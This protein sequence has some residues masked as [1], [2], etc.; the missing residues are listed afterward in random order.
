[1]YILLVRDKQN[2]IISYEEIPL[3]TNKQLKQYIQ[4]TYKTATKIELLKITKIL[5]NIQKETLIYE[6][7]ELGEIL[8]CPD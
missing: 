4:Q 2:N 5:H 1:M 8:P 7:N 3:Y 6:V